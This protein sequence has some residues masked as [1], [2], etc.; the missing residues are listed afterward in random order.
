MWPL[1][2]GLAV[3]VPLVRDAALP[4]W[5]RGLAE[6]AAEGED[7]AARLRDPTLSPSRVDAVLGSAKPASACAALAAGVDVVATWWE[8]WRSLTLAIRGSDLVA[9]GVAPGPAVG[10][11]LRATRAAVLDGRAKTRDEQLRTALE[12]AR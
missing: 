10:R 1:R 8:R 4:G 6:E 5:A 9:A 2:L 7:L 3:P 12:A 11:A